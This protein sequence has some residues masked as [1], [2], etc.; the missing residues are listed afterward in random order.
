[1]RLD[2]HRSSSKVPLPG[3]S[4]GRRGAGRYQQL[5]LANA[6]GIESVHREKCRGVKRD[7]AEQAAGRFDERTEH[8]VA[9][10]A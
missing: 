3:I 2:P 6:R 1:M 10:F 4:T 5:Q 8:G 9:Q 7:E